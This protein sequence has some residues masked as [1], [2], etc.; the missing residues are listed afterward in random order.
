M[1]EDIKAALWKIKKKMTRLSEELGDLKKAE[2]ALLKILNEEEPTQVSILEAKKEAQTRKEQIAKLLKEEGPL[3]RQEIL[4]KTDLTKGTLSWVLH[5]K[6]FES[7]EGRW[8]IRGM[9][10]E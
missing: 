1:S 2:E 5:D 7:R 4:Q 8:H 9:Q 6:D 3:T 10:S